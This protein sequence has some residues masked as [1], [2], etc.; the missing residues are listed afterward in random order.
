M[1]TPTV[2]II[3]STWMR[4]GHVGESKVFVYEVFLND[5]RLRVFSTDGNMTDGYWGSSAEP[6]AKAYANKVADTLG[7]QVIRG[8]MKAKK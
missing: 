4:K 3:S 6:M 5:V 7:V 8:R 1:S 2:Q